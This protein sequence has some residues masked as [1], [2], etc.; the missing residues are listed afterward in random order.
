VGRLGLRLLFAT[1]LAVAVAA[2]G[3]VGARAAVPTTWCGDA[4]PQSPVDRVPD[5][6]AG[7]QVTVIYAHPSDQPDRIA[8]FGDKI[9][10]DMA[11]ADAWWRGQDSARTLRFDLF[12]FPNCTGLARL[13]IADVTLPNNGAYYLP[14]S[15]SGR[16]T[17]IADDLE[18]PALAFSNV[19]KKYVV[20]FDGRTDNTNV[21][22]QGGGDYLTGPNHAIVYVQSCNLATNDVLRPHVAIHEL[23]HAMGAVPQGAPNDCPPPNNGHV[24]DSTLDLLYWQSSVGTSLDTDVL[25]F[26]RNDYYGTNGSEDIRKSAWLTFLDAQVQS[27]VVIGGSGTGTVQSDLPGLNCPGTCSAVWNQGSQFTLTATPGPKTRFVRWAGPCSGSD[28]SCSVTMTGGARIDAVFASQISLTLTVDASRASGTIVSDPA[29]LSCPGTCTADF[30][31]GQV[32]TLTARPGTGSRLEAWGGACSGRDGCSVTVD[33]AKNVTATFAVRYRRLTASVA[34][35]GKIVSTPAGL[36]CP[37]R[38]S[39]QFD[40]GSRVV[41]RAVPAKGYKLSAWSGACR[42]KA[43]CTVTLNADAKVRAT[44]KRR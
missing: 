33:S 29:G 17:R 22:G 19:Y 23:V 31:A 32:V 11:S 44:F 21:C 28:P 13:D 10:T 6:T 1:T 36:S 38:C 43:G 30:D 5:L 41:L 9:A 37:A 18:T 12:A 20:Y 4:G 34:G 24:C 8:T 42:G 15:G 3:S 14:L 26:N 7:Q 40:V 27:D 2:V 16:Y 35:K 25:D 39:S